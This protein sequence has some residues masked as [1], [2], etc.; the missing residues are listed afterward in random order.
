MT[1][2]RTFKPLAA[3]LRQE[4]A[5]AL[6][7]FLSMGMWKQCAEAAE[8]IDALEAERDMLLNALLPYA[9]AHK[10]LG[11]MPGTLPAIMRQ[12][13]TRD[14]LT[15]ARESVERVIQAGEAAK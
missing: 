12:S 6:A 15:R 13:F 4:G 9:F 8:A 3:K 7:K 5:H 2:P 10:A 11:T 1:A 14:Q